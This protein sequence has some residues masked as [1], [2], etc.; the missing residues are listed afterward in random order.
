MSI[1]IPFFNNGSTI[2]DAVKSV[3]AQTYGN[4]ELILLND[5]STDNSLDLVK[6]IKDGRVRV[7]SDGANRGLIYRLNQIP[8]LAY[9]EY[10]ARM[11]GDDLMHPDRIARQMD[12][13]LSDHRI[14]LVD[15]GA[16]SI[17]EKGNPVGIRGLQP[18]SY[19]PK[20]VLRKHLLLHPSVVGKRSWFIS[21]PYDPHFIRAEDYEL[22]CRTYSFS[23]FRRIQEPLHI[24]REG[25]VNIKN[26]VSSL[27]TVRRILKKYGPVV[28]NKMEL[29]IEILK[30]YLKIFIY[31]FFGAFNFQHVLS[32]KRNRILTKAEQKH[33]QQILNKIR[34]IKVS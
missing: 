17:D 24:Y 9:G 25:R 2:L 33:V 10:L 18:I 3:F 14:D 23:N 26:Y 6:D 8:L 32:K 28:F 12:V 1:V 15:T 29:K 7:I 11:D 21:N 16:Y 19:A 4:W 31:R 13:L 20:D 34:A 22:W 30:T 5:G 27:K